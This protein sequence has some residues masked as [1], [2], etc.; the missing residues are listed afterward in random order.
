VVAIFEI[1]RCIQSTMKFSKFLSAFTLLSLVFY[2]TFAQKPIPEL[3]GQ[4]VHDEALVLKQATIDQLEKGLEQYED[5]TS[6]QIAILIIQSLD[7]Q[8]IEEYSLKVAEKWK[9][10]V[11]AKDN[12]VLLLIAIDDHKIRI[13]VGH[14]LEGVLTDALCNRIIRNEMAPNFRRSDYDA[15]VLAAISAIEKAIGGEYSSTDKEGND[16]DNMGT[17]GKIALAA[18]LFVF[19]GIF[20]G[21]GLFSKGYMTW[22]LYAFMMPFYA[23]FM[24]LM[25]GWWIFFGYVILYPLLRFWVIKS[26]RK[27]MEWQSGGGGSGS[28]WS[29][30]GSS[31]SSFS[32]GG[33]S[34]G[35]GGSSGGW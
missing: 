27:L 23:V 4:R 34:F 15:G 1:F 33:G 20:A 2:S 14:G 25:F 29:S 22:V 28:G 13:E 26:G 19:L 16:F 6:N 8:F 17:G 32:G 9:L 31:G 7:G 11:K 18:G 5:S 21:I 30:S 12:G 35:G 24:G 10:G 3:W